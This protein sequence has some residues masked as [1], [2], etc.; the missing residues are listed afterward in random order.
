MAAE[1]RAVLAC[2]H[3][4]KA[5]GVVLRIS[6]AAVLDVERVDVVLFVALHA[7]RF[8]SRSSAPDASF[9][10]RPAVAKNARSASQSRIASTIS[11][12]CPRRS[13]SWRC[14]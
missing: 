5:D 11:R 7:Q 9:V 12:L 13:T 4:G 14:F 8:A 1:Q 3:E 10:E 6:V 2:G